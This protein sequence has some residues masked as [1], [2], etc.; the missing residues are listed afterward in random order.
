MGR[1]LLVPPGLIDSRLPHTPA[2]LFGERGVLAWWPAADKGGLYSLDRM[3]S[4][5]LG[6]KVLARLCA[7]DP[8]R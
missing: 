5:E 7:V 8:I 1:A 3:P 2:R 4:I 6:I